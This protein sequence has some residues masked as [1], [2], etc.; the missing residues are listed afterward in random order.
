M[1]PFSTWHSLEQPSPLFELPSS[2]FSPA[3]GKPLPQLDTIFWQYE[4]VPEQLYPLST[5]QLKEQPSPFKTLL[6]SQVY[7]ASMKPLPHFAATHRPSR[8]VKELSQAVQTVG[9]VQPK[10]PAGH[11]EQVVV[12]EAYVAPVHT[13]GGTTLDS[14]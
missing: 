8:R 11:G 12:E 4:G 10:H 14:Q 5:A 9:L 2:H 3:L 1:Y 13:I 7:P 6:S